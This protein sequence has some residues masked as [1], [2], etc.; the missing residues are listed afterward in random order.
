MKTV[1]GVTVG[2]FAHSPS[3]YVQHSVECGSKNWDHTLTPSKL[4]RGCLMW[5]RAYP[6]FLSPFG[7]YSG[8]PHNKSIH[9]G[10]D[11]HETSCATVQGAWARG[12]LWHSTAC[13]MCM[14]GPCVN[15]PN[16]RC[17]SHVASEK[18]RLRTAI[19]NSWTLLQ[20]VAFLDSVLSLL[21]PHNSA[22]SFERV[23]EVYFQPQLCFVGGA[24]FSLFSLRRRKKKSK[25]VDPDKIIN[26]PSVAWWTC[27]VFKSQRHE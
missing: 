22:L 8:E 21:I 10:H 19:W 7:M 4:Y 15:R 6:L 23:R 11:L 20:M 16:V 25:V 3:M 18:E 27:F 1:V 9:I 14:P 5:T 26:T 17:V 12:L 24:Y 13:Q 2:L